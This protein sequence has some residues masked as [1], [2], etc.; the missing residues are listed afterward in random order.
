MRQWLR[1][2]GSYLTRLLHIFNLL[3]KHILTLTDF[4]E[5]AEQAVET[6]FVFAEKYGSDLTIYHNAVDGDMIMYELVGDPEIEHFKLQDQI[7]S[8]PISK[9]KA[10]AKKHNVVVRYLSGA[11]D[12]IKKIYRITEILDID[13]IVMGSSGAGGKNEFVWGSNT[14]KVVKNVDL[15]VMVIKGPMRDYRIDN[16]VFASSFDNEEKDVLRYALDLLKPTSDAVVHLLSVDTTSFFTQPAVL[17]KTAMKEFETLVKPLNAKSYFYADYSIEAGIRHFMQEV[18][19]DILI[20]SNRNEK[21]IKRFLSGNN[22]LKAI[23]NSNYPVLS[24]DYKKT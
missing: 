23:S 4:S 9:W 24:I 13:M 6:A 11:A 14:E 8:A 5:V 1:N 22:T 15:P 19:P 12:F 10:L 17:M 16:I 21:P 2:S 3:M 20:M 18:Q 7:S